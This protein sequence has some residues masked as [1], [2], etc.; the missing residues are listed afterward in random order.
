ME[1]GSLLLT[2]PT[3]RGDFHGDVDAVRRA[4]A[5]RPEHKIRDGGIAVRRPAASAA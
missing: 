1:I 3:G 4:N 2:D 5:L